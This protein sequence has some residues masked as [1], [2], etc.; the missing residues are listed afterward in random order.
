MLLNARSRAKIFLRDRFMISRHPNVVIHS[1]RSLSYVAY[2]GLIRNAFVN[3]TVRSSLRGSFRSIAT[4]KI[5][6]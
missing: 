2:Q 4:S 1:K 5:G 3:H 6:M